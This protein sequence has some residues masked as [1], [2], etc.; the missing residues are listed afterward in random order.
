MNGINSAGEQ[1]VDAVV[2]QQQLVV[3]RCAMLRC[4]EKESQWVKQSE[5]ASAK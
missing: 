4:E 1:D 2:V 5:G 3:E